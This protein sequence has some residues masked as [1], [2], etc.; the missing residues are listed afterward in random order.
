MAIPTRLRRASF[1][2]DP[3]TLN[4]AYLEHSNK[5]KFYRISPVK[6]QVMKELV[7]ETLAENI[8][9]SSSSAW[10]SPV[11]LMPKKKGGKHRVCVNYFNLKAKTHTEA[12]PTTDYTR[13]PGVTCWI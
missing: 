2:L 3:D 11:V 4:P 7:K 1:I 10:A 6:L 9:E 5:T 12:A 8:L 13:N